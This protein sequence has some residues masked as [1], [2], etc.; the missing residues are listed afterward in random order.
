MN[1]LSSPCGHKIS[2]NI[3]LKTDKIKVVIKKLCV[4]VLY[5]VYIY[6]YTGCGI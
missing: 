1:F 6:I 4:F 3:L 2:D 5:V